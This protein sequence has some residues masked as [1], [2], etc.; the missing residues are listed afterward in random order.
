MAESPA[1]P[2]ES[3]YQHW[4]YP[5]PTDDL[6]AWCNAPD[7][8]WNDLRDLYWAYWP[9][10][11]RRE[12]LEIL[13]AGCGTMAAASFAY[14]YPQAKVLGIDI[15][16][17][18]L[19]H[20][21][22]LKEIYKLENLAVERCRVEDVEALGRSFDYINASGVLHHTAEPHVGLAA[23]GRTLRE[24]GV[25]SVMVYGRYG[26]AGVYM[27]QELFRLLGLEQTKQDLELVKATLRFASPG[28][29]IQRYLRL[30]TDLNVDAG[31]VDTFLHRRD[32][33]YTVRDCLDLVSQGGLA[34]GGWEEPALYHPEAHLPPGHPLIERIS[35]L[36]RPEMW[37]AVELLYGSTGNHWFF[38]HRP[39][40]PQASLKISFEGESF[41][42]Y[43]PVT[44]IKT[45]LA[46]ADS[47]LTIQRPPFPPVQL[48]GL[49]AAV[50]RQIDGK[51]TIRQCLALA[52]GTE[53]TAPI[54][55]G[56][57]AF[58]RSLWR[59]GY[60]LFRL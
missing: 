53:P 23:L 41:L 36:N 3:Q 28:H 13:V 43:T 40:S 48:A 9:H 20:E 21:R 26:R 34:F 29:P 15:S 17:T 19:S 35:R 2:V 27:F 7:N 59:M 37:E 45:T 38:A 25:V 42:D 56:A 32:K 46:G 8:H 5:A 12:E 4:P 22:K 50:F 14:L 51:R 11:E 52:A 24:D 58:F 39:D 16:Q 47:T 60:A 57:R 33:P 30:A 18:S 1:D 6:A 31:V 55:A 44:R 54:A 49:Q 10:R